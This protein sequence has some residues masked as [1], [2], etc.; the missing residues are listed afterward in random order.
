MDGIIDTVAGP[1]SLHALVDLLKTG[2]KLVLVGASLK[3]PE[4]PTLPL[5]MGRQ[6][7]ADIEVVSMDYKNTAFERVA[8]TD[9]KHRF[10]IDV[11]NTLKD[12]TS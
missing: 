5:M 3:N 2:G 11:V 4:L 12:V 6:M 9:V 8:K 1:H 10:V 7:I